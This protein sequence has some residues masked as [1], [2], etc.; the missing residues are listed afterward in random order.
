MVKAQLYHFLAQTYGIPL[1]WQSRAVFAHPFDKEKAMKP[2]GNILRVSEQTNFRINEAPNV[3]S[4]A[5]ISP[6]A[7]FRGRD[8][9]TWP[10]KLLD[11]CFSHPL[12]CGI[13]KFR[14]HK[15]MNASA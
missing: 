6:N 15:W 8:F 10:R 5:E 7:I 11:H 3:T 2:F 13:R 12:C 14:S 1:K 9:E 4:N